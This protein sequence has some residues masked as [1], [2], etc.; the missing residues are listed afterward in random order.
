MR[1]L[2]R[3]D[4][5]I[6]YPFVQQGGFYPRN[7]GTLSGSRV[8]IPSQRLEATHLWETEILARVSGRSWPRGGLVR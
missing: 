6:E 2:A 7:R 1:N 4:W 8:R 5:N 3:R